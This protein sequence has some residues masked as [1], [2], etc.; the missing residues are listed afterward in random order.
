MPD[1]FGSVTS[2][3][4]NNDLEY[5]GLGPAGVISRFVGYD[6]SSGAICVYVPNRPCNDS[7]SRGACID[8]SESDTFACLDESVFLLIGKERIP[9]ATC[10]KT[11]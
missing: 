6:V 3:G 2:L 7:V 11:S 4:P 8:S 10:T 9:E 5:L 1:G